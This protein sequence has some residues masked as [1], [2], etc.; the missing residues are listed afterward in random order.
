MSQRVSWQHEGRFLCQ[1]KIENA[2]RALTQPQTV[3][4]L[5]VYKANVSAI[6]VY[7]LKEVVTRYTLSKYTYQVFFLYFFSIFAGRG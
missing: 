3:I 7:Y 2:V 1:V 5:L 6:D 4:G